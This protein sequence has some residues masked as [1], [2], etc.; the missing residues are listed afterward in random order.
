MKFPQKT[1]I[2]P[3]LIFYYKFS[4]GWNLMRPTL[5][6]IKRISVDVRELLW[7]TLVEL[8]SVATSRL[9]LSPSRSPS[10]LEFESGRQIRTKVLMRLLLKIPWF[11][12]V[13]GTIVGL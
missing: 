11:I 7:P 3:T 4:M 10:N 9:S 1:I 5:I 2:V 13:H 6:L 8:F 12:C